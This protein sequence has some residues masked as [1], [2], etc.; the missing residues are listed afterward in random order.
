MAERCD[1]H[2][3]GTLSPEE[4]TAEARQRTMLLAEALDYIESHGPSEAVRA[5]LEGGELF[6][7]VEDLD[8]DCAVL[9]LKGRPGEKAVI[10]TYTWDWLESHTVEERAA[11]SLATLLGDGCASTTGAVVSQ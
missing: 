2:R 3:K 1:N 7:E 6:D 11:V 9:R 8:I 5:A 10:L 4:Y